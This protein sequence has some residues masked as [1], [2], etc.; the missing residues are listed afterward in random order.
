MKRFFFILVLLFH[1]LGVIAQDST[2][3][4]SLHHQP[5]ALGFVDK[6]MDLITFE[7]EKYTVSVYPLMD[8][9]ERAGLD[10]GIMPVIILKSDREIIRKTKYSRPTTIIP[11][12]AMSTRGQMMADVDLIYYHPKGWMLNPTLIWYRIPD[13]YYGIGGPS[14]EETVFQT[15]T[16]GLEGVWLR[17]IT[18]MFFMG[19]SYD[20]TQVSNK[21]F[22]GE[23]LDSTVLGYD[24]K[25][26]SGLGLD[27][28]FDTRNDILF[29]SKGQ[30]ITLDYRLYFGNFNFHHIELDL[31]SFWKIKNT[32]NV[33][34]VQGFFETILG[35]DVPF[36]KMPQLGGKHHFRA[37]G[38]PNKYLDN[39]IYYLQAEYRRHLIG[40]FGAV[41]FGGWG[42]NR[43]EWNESFFKDGKWMFGGGLRFQLLPKDHLNFRLDIGKSPNEEMAIFFTMRE[44]F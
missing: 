32:K 23:N 2:A 24:G 5:K 15:N 18:D 31:A 34:G 44:S 27:F 30:I 10:F 9:S 42:N 38:H 26:T 8:Y 41:A 43:T 37:I 11:S 14:G 39:Q 33:I 16:I 22:E 28:R 7:R 3:T 21:N 40:R 20:L 19:F 25:F 17:P 13:T 6:M 1:A 36:Y 29:P 4:D 35:D 12:F